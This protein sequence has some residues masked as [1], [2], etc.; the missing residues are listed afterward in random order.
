MAKALTVARRGTEAK[1][2]C[3]SFQKFE[4]V[5]AESLQIQVGSKIYQ[6]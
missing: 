3:I 4:I 6:K 1:S 2:C 5:E